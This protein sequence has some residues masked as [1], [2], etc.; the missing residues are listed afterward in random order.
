A[1]SEAKDL[2]IAEVSH[3]LR[4]PLTPILAAITSLGDRDEL[5]ASMRPVIEM[6]RRNVEIEARLIDDLLDLSRIDQN[7]LHL[8]IAVFDAHPILADVAADIESESR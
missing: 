7:R 2:F 5:P 1:A 6:I 3:E 4:T 8:E